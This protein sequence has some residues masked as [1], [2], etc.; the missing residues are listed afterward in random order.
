MPPLSSLPTKR[1][2]EASETRRVS[3]NSYQ[4]LASPPAESADP[5]AAT[6][7]IYLSIVLPTYKER[8]NLLGIVVVLSYL[9]DEAMPKAYELIVVDDD[10]PDQTWE[11]ALQLAK[12]YPNLRVIRRIQERGLATAVVRGW[13]VAQGE[14]LGVM[15]TDLQ[16]PP[17][18]L[19]E[20]LAKI[21]QGA[22]I[23]IASRNIQGGGTRDLSP[24]Q[25]FLSH[26]A[27]W[28]SRLIL[29]SVAGRVS[30]PMSGYFLVKR[31]AIANRQLYPSG[32]KILLEVLSR[33]SIQSI[34]EVGYVFQGRRE[35]AK[36]R[37]WSK[38]LVHLHHLLYLR[39]NP[40]SRVQEV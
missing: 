34:D 20:L 31:E 30:D 6:H 3:P 38:I 26:T 37:I 15:D 5:S 9:L 16:Q 7:P 25:K 12:H 23:A 29:P 17:E 1:R 33:G 8:T 40:Q 11:V 28:S 36:H 13:E 4:I 27:Q 21:Q 32:Y 39:F 24:L 18:V 10:S 35:K 2:S 19:L 22:D 14:V